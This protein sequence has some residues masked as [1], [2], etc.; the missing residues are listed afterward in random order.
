[1]SMSITAG[2]SKRWVRSCVL[3]LAPNRSEKSL[4][5]NKALIIVAIY[6]PKSSTIAKTVVSWGPK[7]WVNHPKDPNFQVLSRFSVPNYSWWISFIPH[8]LAETPGGCPTLWRLGALLQDFIVDIY[9]ADGAL[10]HLLDAFL[11]A[12]GCPVFMTVNRLYR[13]YIHIYIH[14][15]I[16]I[17]TVYD[18]KYYDNMR[19]YDM[20]W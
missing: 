18:M 5:K 14:I 7:K 9:F 1:M 13:S 16:C 19:W 2:Y 6:S 10:G 8:Q 17:Y 20:I 4:K 15:Y 12:T 11:T 3:R